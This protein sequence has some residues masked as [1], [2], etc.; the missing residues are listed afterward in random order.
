MSKTDKKL[1][2][3]FDLN[4]ISTE[5]EPVEVKELAL[6][7]DVVDSDTDYARKNIRNLIDKGNKIG[8]AHV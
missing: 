2:E 5:I 1:S 3:L 7:D 8:R 6:V 4:P